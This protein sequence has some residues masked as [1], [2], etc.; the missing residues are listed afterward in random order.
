MSPIATGRL[1]LAF[2]ACLIL[3]AGGSLK[4]SWVSAGRPLALPTGALRVGIDASYPPLAVALEGGELEGL[5]V[6]LARDLAQRL[7]VELE[8]LNT[9][10]GGG[11]FACTRDEAAYS[12]AAYDR[13]LFDKPLGHVVQ[14]TAIKALKERGIRWYRIG[15]RPFVGDAP[16]PSEKE[17]A[18]ADFKHGF[19]SHLHQRRLL[20]VAG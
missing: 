10:V 13:E 1:G 11:L 18:I 3:A 19:A 20:R 12:V 15:A 16:A 9:D 17:L 14:F 2:A 8:L 4:A 6:D 7:G 5:E